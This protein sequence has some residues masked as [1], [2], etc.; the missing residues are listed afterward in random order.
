[1]SL[2]KNLGLEDL[3]RDLL[4]DRRDKKCGVEEILKK[5]PP[6]YPVGGIFLKGK[7]VPVAA[8]SNLCDCLAYFIDEDGQVIVVDV[9]KV[10]GVAFGEDVEPA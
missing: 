4:K 9:D 6:N 3:L 7:L 10:S 8:F 5:L 2:N 1:M